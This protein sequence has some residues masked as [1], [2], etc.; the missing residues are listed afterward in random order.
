MLQ[1]FSDSKCA[2]SHFTL[3]IDFFFICLTY[4]KI[5]IEMPE[6]LILNAR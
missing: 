2:S 3:K 6:F 5:L 1:R 4:E